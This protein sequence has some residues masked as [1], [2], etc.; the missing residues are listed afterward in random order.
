MRA[1]AVLA[2]FATSA[3]A[4]SS[5][6]SKN[7]SMLS[8]TRLQNTVFYWDYDDRFKPSTLA[9]WVLQPM[10]TPSAMKRAMGTSLSRP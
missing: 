10:A 5:I 9:A 1:S 8:K 2:A 4:L 7:A 3:S 6:A